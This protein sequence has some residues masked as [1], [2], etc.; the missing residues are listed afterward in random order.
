[1]GVASILMLLGAAIPMLNMFFG[2]QRGQS[3]SQHRILQLA[4]DI[5]TGAKAKR[6]Y[7]RCAVFGRR[8]RRPN[9]SESSAVF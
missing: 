8:L 2:Q 5:L 7:T 4:V 9:G 6:F 1:M 3:A